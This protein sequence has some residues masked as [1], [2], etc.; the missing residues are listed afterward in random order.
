MNVTKNGRQT[1]RLL[2]T[3]NSRLDSIEKSLVASQVSELAKDGTHPKPTATKRQR[4]KTAPPA[5]QLTTIEARIDVGFGNSLFIRGRGAELT[6]DKGLPLTCINGSTWAW[7]TT[8][9]KDKMV[10]K[11]LLNDQIWAKGEDIVIEAGK[12]LELAPAF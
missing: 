1:N 3:K 9:A 12:K 11:L 6:W 7:S 4:K 2:Q 8:Q 5:E 10:F